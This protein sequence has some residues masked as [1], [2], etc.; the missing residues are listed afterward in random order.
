MDFA[1]RGGTARH[2]MGWIDMSPA[3]GR[4]QNWP[5][6]LALL[7][8]V[9]LVITFLSPIFTTNVR[10]ALIFAVLLFT[11]R[12]PRAL[13]WLRS[14]SGALLV[15]SMLWGLLTSFWSLQP[16]LTVMK[17]SAFVLVVVALVSAG[18]RWIQFNGMRPALSFLIPLTLAALMAGVLGR[19][20]ESTLNASR[21]LDLYRG[22][23]SNS[24]MFGSLMFMVSPLLL[25][26]F[27]LSRGRARARMLWGSMLALVF[28]MLLLS[29]SRSNI[30]A[31]MLLVT[32][33]VL[34][35]P[36]TRRTSVLLFGGLA[37][38]TAFLMWPGTL[39]HLESRYVRKNLQVQKASVLNSRQGPWEISMKMAKQGGWFGAGYGVSIDGGSF[40]GGLTAVGYGREK[41]N[42]Q[43][44]I[45]EETGI[46]GLALHA[47]IVLTLFGRMWRAFRESANLDARV[48]MGIVI[49]A[50]FGKLLS[51]V[52]EAWWVAPGAPESIWFWTMVGVALGVSEVAE[53]KTV[54]QARQ[55]G[56]TPVPPIRSR[57]ERSGRVAR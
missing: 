12:R 6:A 52:F 30:L 54:K 16:L 23:T 9:G 32:V 56:R 55:A 48:L 49:G 51:G 33:Y 20:D 34:A 13:G 8:G 22:L 4:L 50:I 14:P 7:G 37:I 42:T 43:L 5:L 41:G 27:H 38:S 2:G 11:L 44:A 17:A 1:H 24:N 39:D 31:A 47:L 25:W 29:V 36:V 46:V 10:W 28:S 19:T 3:I 15:I 53:R 26:Q 57:F 35:L 18:Y 45:M 21:G 40:R